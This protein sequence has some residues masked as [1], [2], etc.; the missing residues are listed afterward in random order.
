MRNRRISTLLLAALL[1]GGCASKPE[2]RD[3]TIDLGA[4]I[5]NGA[6][7]AAGI[8]EALTVGAVRT[9]A[10]LTA[11]DG[12]IGNPDTR[13]RLPEQWQKAARMLR[14]VGQGSY[15]DEIDMTM[16]RAAERA[17]E[18]AVPV[19][20]AVIA[21]MPIKDPAEVLEG[22]ATAGTDLLHKEG[23]KDLR[24]A[25]SPIVAAAMAEVGVDVAFAKA[26][27]RYLRLPTKANVPEVD[28]E[29][30]VLD[31]A[32]NGLFVVLAQEEQRIRQ[33]PTA[34][35]TPLLQRVFG[36]P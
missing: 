21:A 24:A 35:T 25:Y 19:L 36:G 28:L 31:G 32:I 13:L 17:A 5:L 18:D 30:H 14:D 16:N 26:R 3:E 12:Y 10:R 2:V 33:D 34:R 4:E 23:E 27:E 6:T 7:M 29:A 20:A 1:L 22:G 8:R 11:Q 15:M 9:V